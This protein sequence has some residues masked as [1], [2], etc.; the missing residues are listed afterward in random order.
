VRRRRWD[1]AFALALTEGR[2]AA[3]SLAPSVVDRSV[4]A[5]VLA[6]RWRG[7]QDRLD[8]L[9]AE[10]T[11][12]EASAA[13]AHRSARSAQVSGAATALRQALAFDVALRSG[14]NVTT[15]SEADLAQSRDLVQIRSDELLAAVDDPLRP[16]EPV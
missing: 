1:A 15:T 5:E 12:L 14:S 10:L 16:N 3:D 7:S 13:G 4:S 9:Q 6:E 11:R 2:W 8:R